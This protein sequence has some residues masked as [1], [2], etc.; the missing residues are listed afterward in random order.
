MNNYIILL[1]IIIFFLIVFYII[2][3]YIISIYYKVDNIA[4]EYIENFINE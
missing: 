4:N 2:N 1:I 3:K